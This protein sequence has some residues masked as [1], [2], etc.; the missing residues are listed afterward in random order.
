VFVEIDGISGIPR[1]IVE[2]EEVPGVPPTWMPALRFGVGLINFS[3]GVAVDEAANTVYATSPERGAMEVFGPPENLPETITGTPATGV[4]STAADV[5][6]T[7]NPEGVTVTG[8]RFEYGLSTEYG[9]SVPCSPAPPLTGSAAIPVSATL[10][11]HPDETY[12]YRLVA[13]NAAGTEYGEDETFQTEALAPT[14]SE[15]VSAVTQTTGTLDASIDPNDQETT[16]RFEYGT[17]AAYGTVLPASEASI[18]SGYEDVHVGQELSGLQPGTTYHYRVVATN[19][20]SPV[21]GSV[22]PD[23]TFTT[24]PLEPP[25]VSTG[26]AVGVAQNSATL[27]ATIDTQGYQTD[28]EFDFGTETGYGIRIFGNAGVE[29]GA[30]A[31]SVT[32]QGLAPGTTYHYRVAAT[33][34]FGTTYGVDVTFTTASFPASV[35]AAPATAPLIATQVVAFPTAANTTTTT[36]TTTKCAKPKKLS[37]GKC[38]KVKSKKKQAKAKKASRDRRVK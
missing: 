16:Y 33:N 18:G 19:G 15:Y 21:G 26:Q 38:V 14:L 34:T 1:P 7:V 4:T 5:S 12:H 27:T 17:T 36:K 20:S 8:C 2:Y 30:H 13:V 11:A 22:G 10:E 29:P 31:Y 9:A 32:L 6:G 23:Q 24:P 37:H 3:E 25:V 28:Y 35:L